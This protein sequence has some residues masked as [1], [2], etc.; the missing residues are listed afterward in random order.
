MSIER[1]TAK[2]FQWD[3]ERVDRELG[4]VYLVDGSIVRKWGID[5]Q[6]RVHLINGD[7]RELTN[8]KRNAMRKQAYAILGPLVPSPDS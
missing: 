8:E 4:H 2:D 1:P 6:R 5:R 7:E 3:V